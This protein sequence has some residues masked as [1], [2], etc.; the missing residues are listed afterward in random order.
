MVL[1]LVSRVFVASQETDGGH[2]PVLVELRN[3]PA[4]DLQRRVPRLRLPG[5]LYTPSLKALD[6]WKDIQQRWM[7]SP[8]MIR[9]AHHPPTDDAHSLC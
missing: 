2:S 6:K 3:Q 8:A 1:N 5:W 9:L 4:W 7:D